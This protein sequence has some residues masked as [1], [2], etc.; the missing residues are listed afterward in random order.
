M[1]DK[2]EPSL[3]WMAKWEMPR[4]DALSGWT[5]NK[6]YHNQCQ[7]K[8]TKMTYKDSAPPGKQVVTHN[9]TTSDVLLETFRRPNDTEEKIP[10][11]KKVSA[12]YH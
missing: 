2:G 5:Q 12:I 11:G 3:P 7:N 4:I 1:C 8:S 6:F 9:R 10:L